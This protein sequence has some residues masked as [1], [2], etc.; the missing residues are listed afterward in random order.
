MRLLSLEL[1]NFCQHQHRTFEFGTGLIGILGPNGSGKSNLMA[2]A[3]YALTGVIKT[4]GKMK[5]NVYQLAP[6][7]AEAYV[8]LRYQHGGVVA[9]ITRFLQPS[10]DS[11][12]EVENG[13]TIFKDRAINDYVEAT[14]AERSIIDDIVIVDQGEIFGFLSR[15]AAKRAESFAKIFQTDKAAVCWDIIGKHLRQLT[16][17]ESPQ[18][19]ERL[20]AL[21]AEIQSVIDGCTTQ[22][23]G[24]SST[25]LRAELDAARST[26]TEYQQQQRAQSR[27]AE[28]TQNIAEVEEQIQQR[29][30]TLERWQTDKERVE[31]AQQEAKAAAER[32]K[33]LLA[34]QELEKQLQQ[35]RER[36]QRN[37]ADLQA[38]LEQPRPTQPT[39]YSPDEYLG[40][41]FKIN[42]LRAS[43]SHDRQFLRSFDPVR[44]IAECPT[45]HTPVSSLADRYAAVEAALPEKQAKLERMEQAL[46]DYRN[47]LSLLHQD[48]RDRAAVRNTLA[49][50]Q[51]ALEQMAPPSNNE[52]VDE[53]KLRQALTEFDDYVAAGELYRETIRADELFKSRLEGQLEN[54]RSELEAAQAET[55]E[56]V[57]DPLDYMDC[58]EKVEQLPRTITEV[59]NLETNLLTATRDRDHMDGR[60]AEARRV[61][62]LNTVNQLW[63]ERWEPIRDLL[64]RDAAPRILAQTNLSRLEG[65]INEHLSTFNADFRVRASEGSSFIAQ[66]NNH[67]SM[68]AERLSKG[69]QVVLALLYRL[70]VNSM[71]ADLGF[72]SLDEP[73]AYLDAHHIEG[74]E[75]IM[76]KLRL[77]ASSSGL[78]CM[79]ITHE[80]GIAH[81]FDSC[82]QL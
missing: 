29:V 37:I 81:L 48:D 23:N 22:L 27:V 6:S 78:Q 9:T 17:Y 59:T 45:C 34:N 30:A 20:E 63:R 32:A 44:Q 66:F 79:M 2:A 50:D 18:P 33:E 70:A 62:E 4:S 61:E 24:R 56:D 8:K 80:Q 73:T 58:L 21:R 46:N 53:D 25:A 3:K 38:R 36:L 49:A 74:F 72:L 60:I 69:Q 19:V 5:D 13:T 52:P 82:I 47:Y 7:G 68:P 28:L 26:L 57:I 76:E 15:T 42:D 54:L 40:L 67:V 41:D 51:N 11:V 39:D 16:V 35:V 12:L 43:V 75:P 71:Y 77:Y 1:M 65:R 55:V 64:H 10:R 14:I 31:A